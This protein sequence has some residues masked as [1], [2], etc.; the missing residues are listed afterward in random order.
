MTENRFYL[1]KSTNNNLGYVQKLGKND[2]KWSWD[3][4]TVHDEREYHGVIQNREE[5]NYIGNGDWMAVIREFLSKISPKFKVIVFNAGAWKHDDFENEEIQDAV[6][7][8]IRKAGMIS[9]YKTTTTR[10]GERDEEL[11]EYEI[12]AC[13]KADFCLDISWTGHIPDYMYVDHYHFAEPV[14]RLM[15]SQLLGMLEEAGVF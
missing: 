11:A 3:P 6:F 2:A 12:R 8:E 5:V 9:V 15:N 13:E 14:Y 1:D 4:I 7:E 10:L